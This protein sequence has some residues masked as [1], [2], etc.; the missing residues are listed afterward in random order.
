MV[1]GGVSAINIAIHASVVAI[2]L[3]RIDVDFDQKRLRIERA[4]EATKG[5]GLRPKAPRRDTGVVL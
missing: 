3:V 5:R 4:I 1:G 2:I